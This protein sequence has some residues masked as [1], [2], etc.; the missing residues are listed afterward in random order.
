MHMVRSKQAASQQPEETTAARVVVAGRR[1]QAPSIRFRAWRMAPRW[2]L[3]VHF[4][5][6]EKINYPF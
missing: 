5:S 3:F 6:S 2:L 1:S 4:V